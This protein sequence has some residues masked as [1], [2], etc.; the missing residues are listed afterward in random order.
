M[1]ENDPG[2]FPDNGQ[3]VLMRLRDLFLSV[4]ATFGNIASTM[5]GIP[6]MGPPVAAL[7]SAVGFTL[8]ECGVGFDRLIYYWNLLSAFV[9]GG[10]DPSAVIGVLNNIWSGFLD[11]L[12]DPAGFVRSVVGT[13]DPGWGAMIEDPVQ[14]LRTTLFYMFPFLIGLFHDPGQWL[15]DQLEAFSPGLG[16]F[17]TNP[18]LWFAM[19]LSRYFPDLADLFSDP[20]SWVKRK[21]WEWLGV[22][23]EFWSNPAGYMIERGMLY[24]EIRAAT[25]RARLLTFGERVLYIVWEG[26]GE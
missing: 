6:V 5:N 25:L 18:V 9:G 1:A 22:D 15:Y 13:F 8:H 17:L 23:P 26:T 19:F 4:G 16:I 24:I 12:H 7:F 20:L 10:L 2:M 3:S 11:F 14:W 21:A